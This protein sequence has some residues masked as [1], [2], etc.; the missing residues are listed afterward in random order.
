MG[1]IAITG[2]KDPRILKRYSNLRT[3]DLTI[4]ANSVPDYSSKMV[5]TPQQNN[6]LVKFASPKEQWEI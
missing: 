5:K 3:E 2:H 1:V 6:I 4:T